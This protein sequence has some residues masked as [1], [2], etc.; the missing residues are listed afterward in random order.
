MKKKNL[1]I[2]LVLSVCLASITFFVFEKKTKQDI[3]TFEQKGVSWEKENIE[4]KKEE[5]KLEEKPLVPEEN[6]II[7]KTDNIIS[8]V[9]FVLQAPFANWDDPVFQDACEEAAILMTKGW[10]EGKT[11]ST[12]QMYDEIK[13]IVDL[14]KEILNEYVDASAEDTALILKKYS[15]YEKINVVKNITKDDLKQEILKGNL[16]I[17]PTNGQKLDNPYY[18]APGPITHMIVLVGYDSSKKEFV[19]NDSGTKRGENYRYDETV[20]FDAIGNYPTGNHNKNPFSENDR[21]KDMIVIEP[22]NEN[23]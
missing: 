21:G 1:V 5:N 11:F 18:V 2:F 23:K 15:K 19:V 13:K 8:G 3:D 6:I 22:K 12:Q 9:P 17:L 14:E 7:K 4:M 20:L 16:V 10:L